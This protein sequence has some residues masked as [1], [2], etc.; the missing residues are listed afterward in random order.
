M[1]LNMVIG[2]GAEGNGPAWAGRGLPRAM[3]MPEETRPECLNPKTAPR[4]GKKSVDSRPKL[5]STRAV[6]HEYVHSYLVNDAPSQEVPK[7]V[8]ETMNPDVSGF[9]SQ[10]CLDGPRKTGV[11]EESL[12]GAMCELK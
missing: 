10:R 3:K 4:S 6:S 9:T 11:G 12:R 7:Y 1:K 2:V 8:P 5:S